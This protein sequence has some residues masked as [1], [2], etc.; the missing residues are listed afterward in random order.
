MLSSENNKEKHD[1][2]AVKGM[3]EDGD[4]G[5]PVCDDMIAMLPKSMT[6][7]EAM[8]KKHDRKK[9]KSIDCPPGT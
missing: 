3:Y 8:R 5:R 6:D 7:L 2:D 1:F 4:C 9:E